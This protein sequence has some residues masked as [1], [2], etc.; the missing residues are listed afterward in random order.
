MKKFAFNCTCGDKISVDA[1]D[2]NEAKTKF[3]EMM[4]I[5]AFN[6]HFAEK[7]VGE[8]VPDYATVMSAAVLT[9]ET[10]V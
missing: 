10:V 9:E 6:A 4:T 8:A 5:E 1:V 2:M 3:A 7:H